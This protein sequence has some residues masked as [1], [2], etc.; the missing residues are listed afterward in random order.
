MGQFLWSGVSA[1]PWDVAADRFARDIA[2]ILRPSCAARSRQLMPKPLGG[3]G[4]RRTN[5]ATLKDMLQLEKK[6]KQ[7]DVAQIVQPEWYLEM[8]KGFSVAGKWRLS[9]EYYDKFIEYNRDDWEVHFLRAV[10]YQNSR[11]GATTDLL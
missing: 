5:E 2:G 6:A 10:A 8:A 9:A 7:D 4:N 3:C 11:T 1:R